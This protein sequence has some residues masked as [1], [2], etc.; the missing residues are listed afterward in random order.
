MVSRKNIAV[1]GVTLTSF[2]SY[3]RGVLSPF[4]FILKLGGSVV[5]SAIPLLCLLAG[6]NFCVVPSSSVSAI[7]ESVLFFKDVSCFLFCSNWNVVV[8]ICS[9]VV[10]IKVTSH[11][12]L[13]L[14]VFLFL[15]LFFSR[16]LNFLFY[17]KK[18]QQGQ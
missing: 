16:F 4:I 8:R 7:C 17:L 13:E 18:P 14:K 12:F 11:L 3:I 15:V 5:C 2:G 9:Y 6:F 1:V 10:I